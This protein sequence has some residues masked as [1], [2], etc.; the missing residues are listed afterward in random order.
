[1]SITRNHSI[2][3]LVV[4]ALIRMMSDAVAA[5]LPDNAGTDELIRSQQRQQQLQQQLQPDVAVRLDESVVQKPTDLSLPRH[6]TPCFAVNNIILTGDAASRFQFALNSAIARSGFQPGMCLGAQGI[7]HIMTLAQNAVIAR[8][9]TTTRILAAPQDVRSG[10]LELTVIPGRIHAIRFDETEADARHL[11]RIRAAHNA[12]PAQAGDILNLRDLEQGLENLKR[13]P[14]VEADIQIVPAPAPN[15]SDVLVQWAQKTVPIRFNASVDDSGSK[16][17][18][19]YQGS[20]A[21]S[22][23]NPL[24]LSDLFYASYN[25]DLGHKSSYT[26]QDGIR[27]GSGTHGYAFHYSVPF[28]RWLFAF[29]SSRYRYEQAIAGDSQNY[30]Y[31]GNSLSHDWSATRLLY[32]DARRKTSAGLKGWIRSSDNFIDDA[33]VVVQRRKTAGWALD[34]AHKEYLGRATL[35]LGLGYKRGTGAYGALAAPEE[36]FGEGSSR[37]RIITADAGLNLPFQAGK[38]PFSYDSNL[39]IQWHQT[40]LTPQ[41]R[42]SIGGRH[43]VR[44]FDGDL[45]LAGERGWYWRNDLAWGYRPGHQ[46][47]VGADVGHVSGPSARDLVGQTLAGAVVGVKGQWRLG[48]AGGVLAYDAF[49]G[50]PL[51][52]PALFQTARNAYGFNLSYSF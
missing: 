22:L 42:I 29:N 38:Q 1:M 45:S 25:R 17:T 47:Y 27:T 37:M 26:D 43:T 14:T 24:G 6:E 10:T 21:V 49:A 40:P 2:H 3:L 11:E 28:D 52:K 7:N 20:I 23:D 4:V 41:D 39:R 15:Q 46:V 44:G 48:R 8:G 9:Y 32:R 30:V 35:N 16:T 50:R 36:R 13:V 51:K 31:S 34:L 18:G 19:K 33:E 5:S 12:F